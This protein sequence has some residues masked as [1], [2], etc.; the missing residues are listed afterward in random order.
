MAMDISEKKNRFYF[1]SSIKSLPV[2]DAS[3]IESVICC[4]EKS[5]QMLL[6]QTWLNI[7]A[8]PHCVLIF[9]YDITSI[10]LMPL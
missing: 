2:T 3:L 9:S 7:K 4:E 8:Q 5:E 1:L 6:A 10:Q